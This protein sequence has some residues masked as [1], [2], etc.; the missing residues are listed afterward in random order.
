MVDKKEINS[1]KFC[2]RFNPAI[3]TKK[4]DG[5]VM[6][7]KSTNITHPTY[8]N[9]RSGTEVWIVGSGRSSGIFM[10]KGII[11]KTP[12]FL[13]EADELDR[14]KKPEKYLKKSVWKF[15]I[16]ILE[17]PNM[18]IKKTNTWNIIKNIVSPRFIH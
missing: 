14:L 11:S 17:S 3:N 7:S 4:S 2:I 10:Y 1:R 15:S 5:T 12:E 6:Y 8:S 16:D 18:N 13:P 9:L